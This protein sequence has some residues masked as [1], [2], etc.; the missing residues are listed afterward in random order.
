MKITNVDK[1]QNKFYVKEKEI[2]KR[3]TARG[4]RYYGAAITKLG[5]YESVEEDP[6]KFAAI[7]RGAQEQLAGEAFTE[8]QAAI[9]EEQCRNASAT[10][11]E[12]V[13]NLLDGAGQKVAKQL[14]MDKIGLSEVVN[15]DEESGTA[16]EE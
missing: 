15:A 11:V 16:D 1:R 10:T 12:W 14:I 4:V 8:A 9:A 5:A 6:A 13:L 3:K 7:M 2:V